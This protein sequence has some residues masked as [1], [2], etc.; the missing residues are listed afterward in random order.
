MLGPDRFASFETPNVIDP[1][2]E[3]PL[4]PK[5]KEQPSSSASSTPSAARVSSS[6]VGRTRKISLNVPASPS[7][8]SSSY[9]RER[10]SPQRVLNSINDLDLERGGDAPDNVP[11]TSTGTTI[12][13]ARNYATSLLQDADRRTGSTPKNGGASRTPVV[14]EAE[15][16]SNDDHDEAYQEYY[17]KHHYQQHHRSKHLVRQRVLRVA[18]K[19]CGILAL[20]AVLIFLITRL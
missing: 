8:S 18:L 7:S 15:Q 5:R 13:E 14:F 9:N 11:E 20:I 4:Q 1:G 2:D 19:G 3:A 16:P 12:D 17:S 6:V 10:Q